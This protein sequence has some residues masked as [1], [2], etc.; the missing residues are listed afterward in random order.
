[1]PQGAL[2]AV[3]GRLNTGM[4]QECEQPV[5][6]L[7]QSRRQHPH[8]VVL[9]VEVLLAEPEESFLQGNGLPDQLG[10]VQSAAAEP[11][12]QPKQLRRKR[13]CVAAEPFGASGAGKLLDPQRIPFQMSP[14]NW[15]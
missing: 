6:M 8:F 7:E 4:S 15:A 13:Q 2:R 14:T 5:A 9:T 11:M 1:M 12:P 3:V 10:P